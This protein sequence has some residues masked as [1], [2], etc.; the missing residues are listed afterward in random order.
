MNLKY[1]NEISDLNFFKFINLRS[2]NKINWVLECLK[3]NPFFVNSQ[4]NWGS[5]GIFKK[6]LGSLNQYNGRIMNNNL[7]KMRSMKTFLKDSQGN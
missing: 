5:S 7:I 6:M 4:K 2:K 1:I 3:A